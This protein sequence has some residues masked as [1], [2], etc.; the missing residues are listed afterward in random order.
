MKKKLLITINILLIMLVASILIITNKN[1]NHNSNLL[2]FASEDIIDKYE[3]EYSRINILI[4]VNDVENKS[5]VF[6]INNEKKQE[7]EIKNGICSYT[8]DNWKEDTV[9]NIKVIL[10]EI[11]I[12]KSKIKQ[13]SNIKSIKKSKKYICNRFK[14]MLI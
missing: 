8:F 10:K 9:Y 14:I 4:N 12:W 1:T 3:I 2:S 5:C 13:Y 7:A 11:F 6:S